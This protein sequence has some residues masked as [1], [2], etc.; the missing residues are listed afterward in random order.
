MP[1]L[2]QIKGSIELGPG[3]TILK[4]YGARYSDGHV[5]AFV[6]V[7][8]VDVPFQYLTYF[9]E[10]DEEI[11][12]LRV[13]Y[14][15]GEILTGEMKQKCIAVM[16]EYVQGFQDRRGLVT[17]EV[18][19]EFMTPRKLQFVGN[20]NPNPNAGK[21]PPAPEKKVEEKKEEVERHST[22]TKLR[23]LTTGKTADEVDSENTRD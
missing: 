4:E 8:D 17:D 20:P 11:E 14:T 21:A 5:E 1:T 16:Q 22:L 6:A 15:K 19:R 12:R 3:N 13:G 10:D 9:L 7:P 18:L 2:K 23:R